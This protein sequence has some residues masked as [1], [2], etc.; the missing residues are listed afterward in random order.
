MPRLREHLRV[1]LKSYPH[2][3][4]A[5][6]L[7]GLCLTETGDFRGALPE[8]ETSYKLNPRDTSILYALAYAN[9]RAG[10]VD[11][12]AELLRRLGDGSRRSRS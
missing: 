5:R 4:R 12:A 7:L 6:Q 10:D 1:F 2:E 8:L 11:R 9:A 3:P